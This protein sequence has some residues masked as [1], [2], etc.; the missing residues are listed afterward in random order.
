MSTAATE[1]DSEVT[2]GADGTDTGLVARIVHYETGD[3]LTMFPAI[4]TG[5]DLLSRWL[6]AE[7]GSWVDLEEMR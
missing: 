3:E 7:E 4:S 1:D 2:G 5:V 6:T